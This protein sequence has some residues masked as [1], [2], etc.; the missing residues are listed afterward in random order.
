MAQNKYLKQVQSI[1]L[2]NFGETTRIVATSIA[3]ICN[4]K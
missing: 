2:S 4:I 1:D 3:S